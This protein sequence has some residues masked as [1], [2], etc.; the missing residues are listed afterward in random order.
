MFKGILQRASGYLGFVQKYKT[1]K[2]CFHEKILGWGTPRSVLLTSLSLSSFVAP[3]NS[4]A[5]GLTVVAS[6]KMKDGRAN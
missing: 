6:E 5:L 2:L 3:E 4:V 1:G